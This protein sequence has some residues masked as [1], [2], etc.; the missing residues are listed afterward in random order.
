MNI[1]DNELGRI[2]SQLQK[3]TADLGQYQSADEAFEGQHIE[4]NL[5]WLAD[6]IAKGDRLVSTAKVL[7]R[8]ADER[9]RFFEASLFADPAWYIL[10]DLY[11]HAVE[12]RTVSVSSLCVAARVP[13]TTALRWIN[14]L[15]EQG[16]LLRSTD[17]ADRRRTY[18]NLSDATYDRIS[19][20]LTEITSVNPV[21][22]SA[23]AP[24]RQRPLSP[25]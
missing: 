5:I 24:L 10:L 4:H 12:K 22:S 1:P 11:I 8:Q 19:A 20:Y 9:N 16:L 21:R 7:L 6:Y 2:V 25:S 23:T 15:V 14:S 17:P 13:A 18:L 3:L